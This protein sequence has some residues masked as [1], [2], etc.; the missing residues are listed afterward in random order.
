MSKNPSSI[1]SPI[2]IIFYQYSIKNPNEEV[3]LEQLLNIDNYDINKPQHHRGHN[4]LS[5][6]VGNN[7][8]KIVEKLIQYPNINV[9]YYSGCD[10]NLLIAIKNNN[11]DIAR[12]LLGNSNI[13]I[14]NANCQNITPI[15]EAIQNNN[16]DI[17]KLLIK[18]DKNIANYTGYMQPPCIY[19][20]IK[21]NRYNIVKLL[22]E[23]NA[24]INME[25]INKTPLLYSIKMDNVEISKLLLENKADPNVHLD[26]NTNYSCHTGPDYFCSIP[27]TPLSIGNKNNN[28]K[29]IKLLL[30]F[31]A[32]I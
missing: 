10:N 17:V 14:Y 15:I 13:D 22:I 26:I 20:A 32:R 4:I 29:M 19:V 12:L 7:H 5:Y 27:E 21:Y 3:I 28:K 30:E 16:I 23:N 8:T 31:N 18:K 11:N 25:Y 2:D 6:A 24:D 1:N 9:N